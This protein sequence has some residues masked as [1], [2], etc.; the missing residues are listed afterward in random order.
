[1]RRST[2]YHSFS[3]AEAMKGVLQNQSRGYQPEPHNT[4]RVSHVNSSEAEQKAKNAFAQ[5]QAL[6]KTKQDRGSRPLPS[7]ESD[8]GVHEAVKPEELMP[9]LQP[10]KPSF[11]KQTAQYNSF[12][13]IKNVVTQRQALVK[14]TE[15]QIKCLQKISATAL[16]H[17]EHSLNSARSLL[18]SCER[19]G[20]LS[21]L[22]TSSW[23]DMSC[24]PPDN[25]LHNVNGSVCRMVSHSRPISCHRSQLSDVQINEVLP[26]GS[27]IRLPKVIRHEHQL[28]QQ[29][30]VEHNYL[31]FVLHGAQLD[32]MSTLKTISERVNIPL[33]HFAVTQMFDANCV[34]TQICS[35]FVP[36]ELFDNV[37]FLC[38][39]NNELGFGSKVFPFAWETRPVKLGE[40]QGNNYCVLLHQCRET[41]KT[42]EK[43][44]S[45]LEKNGFVNYFGAKRFGYQTFGFHHI[46]L[47]VMRREYGAALVMIA[48]NEIEAAQPT[49]VRSFIH[50][51]PYL[52]KLHD[53][54]FSRRFGQKEYRDLYFDYIPSHIRMMHDHACQSFGWNLLASARRQY[55][56]QLKHSEDP[57]ADM[58]TAVPGDFVA[59]H[60]TAGGGGLLKTVCGLP[61]EA[62]PPEFDDA[63]FGKSWMAHDVSNQEIQSV[64]DANQTPHWDVLLPIPFQ[65]SFQSGSQ[66]DPREAELRKLCNVPEDRSGVF[67]EFPLQLNKNRSDVEY[68]RVFIRPAHMAYYVIPEEGGIGSKLKLA[69]D[70]ELCVRMTQPFRTTYATQR[71]SLVSQRVPSGV[72][73]LCTSK[74]TVHGYAAKH[75]TRAIALNVLLPAGSYLSTFLREKFQLT[76]SVQS[77]KSLESEKESETPLSATAPAKTHAKDM[78]VFDH[79][80][81][82]NIMDLKFHHTD[83][84]NNPAFSGITKEGKLALNQLMQ[85]GK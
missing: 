28:P 84:K 35:V 47:S 66:M 51:S 69:T 54:L 4:R 45:S 8:M 7:D 77:M 19:V 41:T 78:N 83:L 40:F 31:Y 17:V 73:D 29:P 24:L 57:D 36:V 15:G 59:P 25:Y 63:W 38:D 11:N 72:L 64:E 37:R 22:P 33:S 58:N 12:N 74:S 79:S 82:G 49:D 48:Q 62:L 42:L 55:A 44:L 26:R 9:S 13:H 85:P 50:S 53:M 70:E 43:T 46:G 6:L 52:H 1:M 3:I 76:R 16:A 34:F 60:S 80:S 75:N 14:C 2:F 67:G 20:A 65:K 71:T 21:F 56:T 18:A 10:Q 23:R 39:I 32:S 61:W 68:R 81:T 30:T 5:L 27:Y